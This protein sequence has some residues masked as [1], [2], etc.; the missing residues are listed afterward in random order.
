MDFHPA[1]KKYYF[2]LSIF[3]LGLSVLMSLYL[4]WM[5]GVVIFCTFGLPIAMLCYH[6]F[7]R[8]EYYMY[9]NLGYTRWRLNLICLLINILVSIPVF[10]IAKLIEWIL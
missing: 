3:N 10:L 6:Y 7:R 2:D 4:G 5:Y 1:V 8:R 9:Y